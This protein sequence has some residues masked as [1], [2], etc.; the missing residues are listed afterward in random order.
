MSD[1]KPRSVPPD[2]SEPQVEDAG[3]APDTAEG[4]PPSQDEPPAPG[5]RIPPREDSSGT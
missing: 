4:P 3:Q 2:D 5:G 1:E